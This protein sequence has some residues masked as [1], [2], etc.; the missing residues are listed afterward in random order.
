MPHLLR[1]EGSGGMREL[2]TRGTL[3]LAVV[4]GVSVDEL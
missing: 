3:A 4:A 2:R 1:A